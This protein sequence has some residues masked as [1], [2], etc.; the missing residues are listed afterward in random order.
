MGSVSIDMPQ[1]N[2]ISRGIEIGH[3]GD[4]HYY[5]WS[6]CEV[7]GNERW[8]TLKNGQIVSLKCKTCSNRVLQRKLVE[9]H[10]NRPFKQCKHYL[11]RGG[12]IV[13]NLP[14][15]SFFYPMC[16]H[17]RKNGRGGWVLEH[18]LVMAKY[19]SRCLERWEV[20]HHRNGVRDDNRQE[21][22]E[23]TTGLKHNTQLNAVIKDLVRE[24]KEIK[25]RL[26][27]YE[28]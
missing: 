9:Y 18:R 7:C 2:D 27:R 6:A 17:S 16:H 5:R 22:L 13:V 14:Y 15:S 26:A 24:N 8:V 20:V 11:E 10:K 3:K 12:Y 21:N 23:L 19:L 25:I 28:N 1:L 4:R